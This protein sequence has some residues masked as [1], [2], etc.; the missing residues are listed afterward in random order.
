[1]DA[2]EKVYQRFEEWRPLFLEYGLY[3][4]AH[5]YSGVDIY[6]LKELGIPLMALM[7]D[8]QRYFDYQ[9]APSDVFQAVNRREM[10]LGSASIAMLIY[11]IDKYGFE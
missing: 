8:S 4:I 7:T 5:G 3:D 11:L 10:Q 2:N 9:H 6:P 1:V